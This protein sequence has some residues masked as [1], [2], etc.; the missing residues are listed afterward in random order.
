[1]TADT[2]C[3]IV[4]VVN[5]LST[6]RH[7]VPHR[8]RELVIATVGIGPRPWRIEL[9]LSQVCLSEIPMA[10]SPDLTRPRP[11]RAGPPG[12]GPPRQASVLLTWDASNKTAPRSEAARPGTPRPDR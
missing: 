3:Q 7:L 1:M 8:Q 9:I 5:A 6:S 11:G 12:P 2:R 4:P 10:T